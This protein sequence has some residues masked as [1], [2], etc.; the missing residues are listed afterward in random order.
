MFD[1]IVLL[2]ITRHSLAGGQ[3]SFTCRRARP[4]SPTQTFGLR[5][6]SFHVSH[7]LA[8]RRLVLGGC[9]STVSSCVWDP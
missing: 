2:G 9:A 5:L 7:S 8:G 6:C 4:A 3:A 1:V